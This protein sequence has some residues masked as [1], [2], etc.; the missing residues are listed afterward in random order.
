MHVSDFGWERAE[1]VSTGR[2]TTASR[3]RAQGRKGGRVIRTPP[4]PPPPLPTLCPCMDCTPRLTGAL[5]VRVSEGV[6][7]EPDV[8]LRADPPD[9][10]LA[11]RHRLERA[12]QHLPAGACRKGGGAWRGA[13]R[14]AWQESVSQFSTAL[15]IP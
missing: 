4:L 14:G 12:G 13:W 9:A 3:W 15:V 8:L 7:P 10:G 6:D 1:F 11:H 2:T 5:V